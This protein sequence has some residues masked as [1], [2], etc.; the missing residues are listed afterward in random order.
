MGR[1]LLIL[2]TMFALVAAALAAAFLLYYQPQSKDLEDARR[3]ASLLAQERAALK[4]RVA[5]LEHM[6]G[7]LRTESAR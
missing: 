1:W 6:L 5:D 7:E 2:L 3:E 4:G